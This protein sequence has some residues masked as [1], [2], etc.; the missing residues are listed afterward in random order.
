MGGDILT[1]H[2]AE[3]PSERVQIVSQLHCECR[4]RGF[5]C[6]SNEG[7]QFLFSLR[8][9]ELSEHRGCGEWK[10]GGSE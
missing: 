5:C 10:D 2:R 1:E 9:L 4:L 6:C 7:V 3:L 8:F